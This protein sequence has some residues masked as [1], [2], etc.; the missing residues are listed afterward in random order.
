MATTSSG[1]TAIIAYRMVEPTSPASLLVS[2]P[3]QQPPSEPPPP[4]TTSPH[5][6]RRNRRPGT[7]GPS[8]SVADCEVT[9]RTNPSQRVRH[10]PIGPDISDDETTTENTPL[11]STPL[12]RRRQ[13]TVSHSST[14]RSNISGSPSF[15]QI[16]ISAFQPEL[17]ADIDLNI[18]SP[19]QDERRHICR[20]REVS[21][22]TVEG[23]D[24]H[25]ESLGLWARVQRYFRPL[26]RKAYYFS[27]FHLLVLNFPFA[28]L[29][30]VYLFV[31]TL[32]GQLSA[33]PCLMCSARPPPR[34]LG[35]HCSWCCH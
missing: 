2:A 30:W 29:A 14:V 23:L 25:V 26:G 6:S 31:F 1:G 12:L 24:Q 27:V 4:Y 34:R 32:V 15:A 17:D 33:C 3:T 28:L 7:R 19:T 13:R 16:L 20:R 9:T 5:R 18:A 10:G 21:E 8:D 22:S 11:L 35:R